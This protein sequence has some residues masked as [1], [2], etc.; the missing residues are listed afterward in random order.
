MA[1]IATRV[2]Y[3]RALVDLGS[4]YDFM[5]LDADLSGSTNTGKFAAKFPERFVNC[6]IA[7]GNMMSIAAGIA[8]TGIKVFASTFAMFAAG[9]AYEQI[10][11]SIVYPQLNVKVCATHAGITV[12]EDGVS[13]QCLEDISLM[14]AIPGM[15][16][17]SPADDTEAYA[18]IEPI[19]N[20][21]GPVYCR[22]GRHPV[23]VVFDLANY[24]FELGKALPIREGSDCTVFATGVM[25]SKAIEAYDILKADGINISVVNVHT[26]KP[27]DNE[28][29]LKYA[30]K[31]GCVVTAEEHFTAGGLGSAICELLSEQLPTKVLRVGISDIFCQSGKAAELLEYYGLTGE[32]I[33][34][35]VRQILGVSK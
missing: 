14:R 22:L 15:T 11:N 3:G 30:A 8:S 21:D 13:H 12:G 20:L 19:L 6:G 2:S 5:V 23:P 33:A 17:V 18:C 28:T 7:E 10:R 32:G 25:V 9:R 35:K 24:K 27:L 34:G 29:M 1:D 26:I 4:K 16:V 31:T